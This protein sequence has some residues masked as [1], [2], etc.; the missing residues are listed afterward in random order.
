MSRLQNKTIKL[1][2]EKL[3]NNSKK[4]LGKKY[5]SKFCLC[6]WPMCAI[7]GEDFFFQKM[8]FI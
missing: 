1:F 7:G 2:M 5:F 3:R 4:Y 6:L 8:T